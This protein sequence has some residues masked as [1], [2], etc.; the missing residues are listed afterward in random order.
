MFE[1]LACPICQKSLTEV[2]NDYE[3]N[4]KRVVETQFGFDEDID[5]VL[6]YTCEENHRF[7]LAAET[8]EIAKRRAEKEAEFTF[9]GESK[10]KIVESMDEDQKAEV[11]AMLSSIQESFSSHGI[12]GVE[13]ADDEPELDPEPEPQPNPN[14]VSAKDLSD[15]ERE[16]IQEQVDAIKQ[17]L[18]SQ[19]RKIG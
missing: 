10:D 14:V 16:K 7:Y 13:F 5:V 6:Q 9:G 17:R 1:I 2:E 18:R 8:I 12:T 11:D 15:E 19:I 4:E 3:N